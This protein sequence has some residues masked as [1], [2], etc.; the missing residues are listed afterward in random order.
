MNTIIEAD[1]DKVFHQQIEA[2]TE[3]F[4]QTRNPEGSSGD[5]V[6]AVD[7]HID[8]V[9]Q[10][11]K[12]DANT[13][14]GKLREIKSEV[15]KVDRKWQGYTKDDVH[16]CDQNVCHSQLHEIAVAEESCQDKI[17]EFIYELDENI[18]VDE[19]RIKSLRSMSD[20]LRKRVKTN[21]NEVKARLTD[22]IKAAEEAKPMSAYEQQSIDL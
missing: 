12:M 15:G 3:T 18:E 8:Q 11:S 6:T 4:D 10:N 19:E 2:P 21:S 13:Y 16:L 9:N 22:L 17:F 14:N 1:L 7:T 5:I 20:E